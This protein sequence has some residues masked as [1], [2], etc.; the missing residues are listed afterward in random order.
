[1]F[2]RAFE[3]A[4]GTIVLPCE[5]CGSPAFVPETHSCPP[6]QLALLEEMAQRERDAWKELP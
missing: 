4:D 5:W 3:L 6:L 2:G 1:M